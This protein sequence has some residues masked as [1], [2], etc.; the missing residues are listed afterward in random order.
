A[1]SFVR[2]RHTDSDIV[3]NA[4]QQDFIRWAKDQYGVSNLISNRDTLLKIF[5]RH[6][7]TDRSLHTTDGLI[8]LFNLVAFSAGHTIRQIPFPAT[9]QPCPVTAIGQA[10]CYVTSDPVAEANVYN[11]LMT[12]TSA[13]APSAAPA[14]KA[15]RSA[16]PSAKAAGLV[17]DTADGKSQAAALGKLGMPVYYPRLIAGSSQYC[18]D[19]TANCSEAPN[20]A[21]VYVGAYPR[22]YMLHDRSGQPHAAYRMTL[23]INPALGEYYGVEGTTWRAP[24]IL[25][26]PQQ[27]RTVH[28]KRLLLYLNGHH[29]ATVGWRTAQAAYW[30]SNTLNDALSNAAMIDIA[31]SLTRAR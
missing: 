26:S 22:G 4:R 31:A 30:V 5:G 7:Q 28:G 27:T 11:Q 19:V 17:A 21:S 10:P 16:A 13:P 12:P 15:R 9:L 1:L 14:K 18:M 24:P 2:F 25:G 8:N 23:V 29:I 3:R 6:T 20:P